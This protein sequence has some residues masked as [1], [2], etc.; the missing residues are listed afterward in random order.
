MK[1]NGSALPEELRAVLAATSGRPTGPITTAG[2]TD[3]ALRKA[4]LAMKDS[5]TYCQRRRE[6]SV[7]RADD[8]R[9]SAG[10]APCPAWMKTWGAALIAFRAAAVENSPGSRPS[11]LL[12][13]R[14]RGT[15]ILLTDPLLLMCYG[16]QLFIPRDEAVFLDWRA[17]A[18]R[19]KLTSPRESCV[20]RSLTLQ[21]A[22]RRDRDLRADL[23]G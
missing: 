9:N 16:A 11:L 17:T 6:L 13:L 8:P 15:V 5:G 22:A 21:R 14:F 12:G 4:R 1:F 3:A 10:D 23:F 2:G 7:V 18:G 19:L 20:I